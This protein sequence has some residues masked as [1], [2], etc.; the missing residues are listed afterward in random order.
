MSRV[1]DILAAVENVPSSPQVLQRVLT[2]VNDPDFS[3]DQLM[4]IV[5]LDP[6][7]TAAVLR[8]C[9][10]AYFGLQQPVSSLQQALTYLGVNNIVDVVMSSEVV[11]FYKNSLESRAVAM[12]CRQSSPRS[13][14]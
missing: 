3:F 7:I 8:M 13:I 2:L 5:S 12:L 6:G 4:D 1:E 10:S 9:N 14:I 11:G